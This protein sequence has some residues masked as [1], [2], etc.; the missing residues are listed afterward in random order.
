MKQYFG[1]D[2][3][4]GIPNETLNKDLVSKIFS[5][6]E[7]LL[8]PKSV[9]VI[10]D[11]RSSSLELLD[12]I[13]AGLSENVEVINYG[14]LPSGS[15]PVL[16]KEFN[17]DLG[18]IISASHNPSEY[19]GIKLIDHKGSKL[20][21]NLEIDIEKALSDVNLPKEF[22]TSKESQNGYQAYLE[23]LNNLINFDL[24]KFNV[25]FDTANGSSYKIIEDL[26][27][28]KK[29]KYRI[30]SNN[31]DA[32]GL[33]RARELGIKTKIIDH[34]KFISRI[35][36]EDELTKYL[37]QLDVDLIVLAG[38]MRILGKKI[39]EKFSSKMINLH[40]SLLPLYPGLNT[41]NKVLENNDEVHGI[42]IH[43]VSSE[44]DAGPLIAQGII[45]IDK[46][47][48]FESLVY[49]IHKIE[50]ELL[51][52]VINE[53]CNK[54]IYLDEDGVKFNNI[55]LDNKKILIKNYEI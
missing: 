12:W 4:R 44:L 20:S 2:G 23:F 54:N 35:K 21:D 26:F 49:R 29:A 45:K 47:E 46:N 41:H 28:S 33:I 27:K 6:V 15:M 34:R 19:N 13:C 22:T 24:A 40:P 11:T 50:H 39:T 43:F 16:L 18:V 10:L 32:F 17:H 25:L 51:P 7:L 48:T 42:S 9:A 53:I 14:V 3:I 38:F 5:S 52:Q 8:S 37:D 36:F 55:D 1:T 31:P 30:I